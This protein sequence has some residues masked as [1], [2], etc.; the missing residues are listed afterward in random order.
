M[1]MKDWKSV[2]QRLHISAVGEVNYNVGGKED[3]RPACI[4]TYTKADKP[5]SRLTQYENDK[6]QL[7]HHDRQLD[8][9]VDGANPHLMTSPNMVAAIYNQGEST[10]SWASCLDAKSS[11]MYQ[12]PD[13]S[14]TQAE[15]L[16]PSEYTCDPARELRPAQIPQPRTPVESRASRPDESRATR[17]D[18][19]AS[20]SV[21]S[22]D[23]WMSGRQPA[24]SKGGGRTPMSARGSDR[25]RVADERS[26]YKSQTATSIASSYYDSDVQGSQKSG[27]SKSMDRLNSGG[28]RGFASPRSGYSDSSRQ[29][30]DQALNQAL[31]GS[32][33]QKQVSGRSPRANGGRPQTSR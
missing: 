22:F 21:Q 20:P 1:T 18:S 19:R 31:K 14:Q 3:M 25:R 13:A 10:P 4:K 6:R 28:P 9:K 15:S 27:R 23:G 30:T 33:S 7:Q 8:P 16:A 32:R 24:S 11:Y 29:V 2:G 17:P 5:V 12:R 26:C